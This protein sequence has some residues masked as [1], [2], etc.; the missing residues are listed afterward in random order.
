MSPINLLLKPLRRKH[1]LSIGLQR[2]P[3]AVQRNIQP[4]SSVLGLL[5]EKS[6][7]AANTHTAWSMFDDSVLNVHLNMLCLSLL[8]NLCAFTFSVV[9][10][11]A[12]NYPRPPIANSGD[13]NSKQNFLEQ[14]FAVSE[15]HDKSEV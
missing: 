10:C 7:R 13:F 4:S 11:F 2:L 15:L 12:Q 8:L 6:L 5:V 9:F 14:N 3:N 1:S